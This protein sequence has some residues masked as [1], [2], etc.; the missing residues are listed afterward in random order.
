MLRKAVQKR[1]PTVAQ[2]AARVPLELAPHQLEDPLEFMRAVMADANEDP[3]LRLD[4]AKALASFTYAKPGD[5][6]KKDEQQEKAKNAAGGKFAAAAT[7]PTLLR[8]VA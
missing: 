3:K 4:A 7:P 6:G 5:K 8:K 2:V 1:A